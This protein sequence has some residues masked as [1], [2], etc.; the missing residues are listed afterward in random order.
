[1]IMDRMRKVVLDKVSSGPSLLQAFF[2]FAYEYKLLHI[3][4][5]Y[6]TPILNRLVTSIFELFGNI[7]I[8]RTTF[9]GKMLIIL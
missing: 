8:C 9:S 6:D 4:K 5:G 2:K 1:M 7:S 3:R